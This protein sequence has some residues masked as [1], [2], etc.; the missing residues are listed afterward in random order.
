MAGF[1]NTLMDYAMA[2]TLALPIRRDLSLAKKEQVRQ[3]GTPEWVA[4][5]GCCGVLGG[6]VAWCLGGLW[7]LCRAGPRW[8]AFCIE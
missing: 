4:C 1:F 6:L 5:Q 2:K 3:I 8:P 7:Q